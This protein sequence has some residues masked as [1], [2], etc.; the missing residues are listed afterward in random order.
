[1]YQN[2]AL[3]RPNAGFRF[4][5][6]RLGLSLL[7]GAVVL[8]VFSSN[9]VAQGLNWEGQTGAFITPFAYTSTSPAA[10]FG[11]PQAS[12]HFMDTG[13]VIGGYI[14]TSV[15]VGFLNARTSSSS[16]RR[17]GTASPACR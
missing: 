16:R 6:R 8:A 11:R 2:S 13:N 15:T 12:F 5:A 4:F 7:L 14:Q 1:M 9:A 3:H 17:S 10:G